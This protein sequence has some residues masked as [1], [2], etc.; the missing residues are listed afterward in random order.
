MTS[1]QNRLLPLSGNRW[2]IA[3]FIGL[4]LT[5]CSPKIRQTARPVKPVDTVAKKTTSQ[6][7]PAVPVVPQTK[8]ISLLLPFYL[9]LLNL[10][11]GTSTA[12][13]EKADLAVE[14]YQGFKLALDSL[15]GR[16]LNFKLQVYDTKD[17][18][19]QSRVLAVNPK[20]RTSNVIIGPVYPD[21]LKSFSTAFGEL[22]KMMVS[23]LSPAAP[24]DYKNPNLITIIPPLEYH[25]RR[26]ASYINE[27]KAKKV[28]VLRSGFS[29]EL[30]YIIPFKKAISNSSKNQVDVVTTT[31]LHGN[32][33]SLLPQLSKT[34]PNIFIIPATDQQFL[35]ITLRSLETLAKQYPVM[36]FGHPNWEKMTFLRAEQ[37]Q[38]LN[39]YI[40]ST[41]HI[42]YHSP[43]VIQFV[44]D[45]RK[46]YH[47][48]P[49]EFAFKGY[50]EGMYFGAMS[51]G[52]EAS[53]KLADFSGLHNDFH[54]VYVK[55]AGWINT[56]VNLLKYSNFDLKPVE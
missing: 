44:K 46:T 1:V 17:E 55:G 12:G 26:V 7:K 5:A 8:V 4:L 50:D 56:H 45:F 11:P 14:Y 9:D 13:L 43:R 10:E 29:E 31:I 15:T 28:F 25:A 41:D 6:V 32:L 23:P 36:L 38:K 21:G 22:K 42:N 52:D 53:F 51:A 2:I 37:L 20:V 47:A 35:Q 34:E 16:G 24:A 54:F 40:T 49:G 3:G 39:T 18:V 19:V 27:L 33:T 30:K 48:E